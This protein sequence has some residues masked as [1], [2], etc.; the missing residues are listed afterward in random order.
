MQVV[1]AA[2][3]LIF[4]PIFD[5]I[6]YP[7]F[8]KFNML[9]T[10]LQKIVSGG[11]LMAVSFVVAALIEI[12]LEKTY[13]SPPEVVDG[14]ATQ[15]LGFHNALPAGCDLAL[16]VTSDEY[17][18]IDRELT[19]A[20][21]RGSWFKSDGKALLPFKAKSGAHIQMDFTAEFA[22]PG[23]CPYDLPASMTTTVKAGKV[24]LSICNSESS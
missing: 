19:V 10:P 8:G 9:K 23:D 22:T 15:R 1:N 7:V 3:I 24:G 17:D 16:R 5:R 4:I 2:F 12:Q 18:F 14:M 6:I 13:P 11:M 21:T 20:A